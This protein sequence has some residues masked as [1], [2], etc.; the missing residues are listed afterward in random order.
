[1]IQALTTVPHHLNSMSAIRFTIYTIMTSVKVIN[2]EDGNSD[3]FLY[4]FRLL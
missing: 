3:T 4:N 2:N 1:M